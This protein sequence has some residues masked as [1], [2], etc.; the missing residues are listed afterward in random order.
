MTSDPVLLERLLRNLLVNAVRYTASGRILMGCRHRN[1]RVV[2]QVLDTGIGIP[3]EKAQVV[4]DDFVRLDTPAE[5]GG[6]RGLGLGLGVVRRMAALLG[7]PLA[8]RS[9]PGKGSCFEVTVP[10]A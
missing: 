1:G 2:I 3:A 9:I 6:S 10:K 7:H 8:L 5:R 4:F